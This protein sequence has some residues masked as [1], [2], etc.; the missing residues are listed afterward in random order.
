M[1]SPNS[2]RRSWANSA[3]D[4]LTKLGRVNLLNGVT[5]ADYLRDQTDAAA[6][7]Q[8]AEESAAAKSMG[9][10]D[11]HAG[12]GEDVGDRITVLGDYQQPVQQSSPVHV[13]RG[14]GGLAIAALAAGVAGPLGVGAAYVL[15]RLLDRDETPPAIVQPEPAEPRDVSVRLKRLSDLD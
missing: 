8:R 1:I 11:P 3:V 12:E 2:P 6:R 15:P 4:Y 10:N 7:C 14:L 5:A 9:W 13:R